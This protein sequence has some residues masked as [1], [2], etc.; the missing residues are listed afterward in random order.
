VTVANTAAK[1][2][3]STCLVWT[4]VECQ[5]RAATATDG[6]GR[7]AHSYGSEG[8][9]AARRGCRPGPRGVWA[10]APAVS[11]P[12]TAYAARGRIFPAPARENPHPCDRRAISVQLAPATSGPSRSLTDT[13][14]RRSGHV[15]GRSRTDSQADST[16]SIRA[17][18]FLATCSRQQFYLDRGLSCPGGNCDRLRAARAITRSEPH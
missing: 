5:P 13:P 16:G 18:W 14:T 17:S 8:R 11:T 2:L 9:A 6:S 12:H 1:P 3:D 10:A 15:E 7:P 4:A